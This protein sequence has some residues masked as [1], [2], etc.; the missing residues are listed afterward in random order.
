MRGRGVPRPELAKAR[1]FSEAG[2]ARTGRDRTCLLSEALMLPCAQ[3]AVA[4]A[5]AAAARRAAAAPPAA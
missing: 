5:V 4:R 3:A 2:G 1:T